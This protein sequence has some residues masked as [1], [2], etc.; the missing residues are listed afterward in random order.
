[1]RNLDVHWYEGLFLLPQHLQSLER[2]R[3]ELA[4]TSEQWDH[5]YH[6]GLRVLEF[7]R[8]ALANNQ[9][10]VRTL[11]A[12]LRDGTLIDL[13]AGEELDRVDVKQGTRT[14]AKAG[15]EEAFAKETTILVY[16]G[17]PRLQLG[18]ENVLKPGTPGEARW[19]E[20]RLE[21]DDE[22]RT[23]KAK[24]LQF[25]RLNVRLLLSTQDLSG[26]EL[27][28]I[29]QIKRAGEG[30]AAPQLDDRYIPPLLAIDAWPGLERDI[31]RA[32]YDMLGQKIEVLS[33]Q[34]INRGLSRDARDP[35]DADRIAMLERL[36]EAYALLGVLAFANGIHPL[37]VYTELCRLVG[38]LSIFG[39]E[40]RVSE[41]PR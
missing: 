13:D 2:Y 28:P 25:R 40:R 1:M 3:N 8:E 14:S 34:V 27:L 20:T 7:S 26:Y 18:R 15:L 32:I 24:E 37:T 35:G 33:Q 9:F 11:K 36:N 41:I 17:V 23:S 29:A 39:P 30:E 4:H 6:Y 31:V 10:E 22:N 19:V 38:Q 21:V 12:R 16:V 5:P